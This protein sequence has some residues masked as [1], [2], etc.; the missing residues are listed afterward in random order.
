MSLIENLESLDSKE[1]YFISHQTVIRPDSITTKVRVVFDAS[2]R[3]TQ[4][5]SLNDKLLAGPNLQ[6]DL[7]QIILRFRSHKYVLTGDIEKMFRQI[8]IHPEDRTLQ[9]ILWRPDSKQNTQVYQLNTVTYGTA[10]APFHAMRCLQELATI[11]KE[12]YPLAAKAI[13][14]D[15]YMDDVLTGGKTQQ[16]VIQ[17][18][19]QLSQLLMQDKEE[20]IKTLGL[21]WNSK[22]DTLQYQVKLCHT[23]VN[24]KREVLSEISQ[25]FDP[26]ASRSSAHSRKNFH[27]AVVVI[28]DRIKEV[29]LW[30]DS[31][32]VL[33]WIKTEPRLLKTFVANRVVKIQE[34]T[35]D[36]TWQHVISEENPAD[37]LSRGMTVEELKICNL[38]WN[39]PSWLKNHKSQPA[40]I[41]KPESHLP[42]L[43]STVVLLATHD[44]ELLQ[45]YSSFSK[46]C[47]II[48]YCQRFLINSRGKKRIGPLE[49]AEIQQAEETVIRWLQAECFAQERR[50][51]KTKQ[52][53][54]RKSPIKSL[55]PFLDEKGLI[56][57]G[58]RLRYAELTGDQKHPL[59]LPA[60]H[61]LTHLI[62]REE[63]YHM[64]HCPPEQLLHI[65]RQRFWPVSGRREAQK[66]VKRCLK[67]FRFN[68]TTPDVPMGDLP[69][70]RVKMYTRPFT[71]TGVD[72]AGPLQIRE[73]RRR[74]KPRITKGYVVV[75]TCFSTKAVHLELVSDLS[76]EAFLATL[77]RFTARRGICSQIFSDNGTNF[78]GA[79]N[80]LKDIQ[81]FL[82]KATPE[83]AAFLSKQ[84]IVWQFI[85]PRSPHFGGLWEAAVKK[86]KRHLYTET[87]GKVLLYKE[88][89]TLLCDI[90]AILNSRPLTP[91]TNDPSDLQ[92]LTP[93]H[94][95]TGESL[96]QPAEPSYNLIPDNRLSKWQHLQK[97]RQRIW[98][99]WQREYLQELQTRSKW[100]TAGKRIELNTLVLMMEDNTPPLRW[101]L[102][103]VIQVY[104]GPDE[105]IRV[106]MVKTQ[107]GTYKRAVKK[108]CP[109][110]KDSLEED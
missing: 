73:S 84:K 30:S 5:T 21:Y 82:I 1:I 43:K 93:A 11:Y 42:E 20:A 18:Q 3:T 52:D 51:L 44:S 2:A 48:A 71:V 68:P 95:I 41:A 54:P 74:G 104:P 109:L 47:R 27:A 91:L 62:M 56:R 55:R 79:A 50:C 89:H 76:T 23:S 7:F 87:Q 57:V 92:V 70:E 98:V 49:V 6:K 12:E 13:R 63:H 88:Y 105:E 15:F 36:T 72:Y 102:G 22:Q 69:K 77:R 110:P 29:R 25:I 81:K 61:Y 97:T 4:G 45:K 101:P 75:F 108:L 10:S 85:P 53:L 40:L 83:I 106:A 78:V 39:G 33:G 103:R 96:I 31:T 107:S 99:R 64:R 37:L 60:K 35:E 16:E 86:M 14:E 8:W 90:E 80:T 26:L 28:K 100:H 94:F 24:S 66:V 17:L 58:G 65:I 67:C 34:L 46:L 9:L 19:Q 38:W 59:I 32:I